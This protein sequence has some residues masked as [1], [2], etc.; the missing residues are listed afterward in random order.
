MT[1][2][3]CKSRAKLF[4]RSLIKNMLCA[5]FYYSGLYSLIKSLLPS[6]RKNEVVVLTFHHISDRKLNYF[7]YLDRDF[8][9]R[10]GRYEIGVPKRMFEKQLKD[11]SLNYNVISLG[12]LT[13]RI[14]EKD[15]MPPRS[16]VVTFDDGYHDFYTLAYPVLKKYR[17]PATVFII[18]GLV[19]LNRV[20]WID[21]IAELILATGGR[22]IIIT[23]ELYP[24]DL[25]AE[26]LNTDLRSLER[27]REFVSVLIKGLKE[28]ANKKRG[29]LVEDIIKH[30][31]VGRI[32]HRTSSRLMG[33]EE[34]AEISRDGVAI[35]SH[36]LTH[37]VLTSLDDS[38]LLDEVYRSKKIL[39]Q[40]VNLNIDLFCYPFGT[41]GSFDERTKAFLKEVGYRCALTSEDG[42]NDTGGDPFCLKRLGTMMFLGFMG[43]YSRSVLVLELDGFFDLCC[44][45]LKQLLKRIIA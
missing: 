20:M 17:V 7:L 21:E 23:P 10:S 25:R 12:K 40:K 34:I 27:R 42:V 33:W 11:I 44:A 28:L 1:V 3:F 2:E 5:F 6:F 8:R 29:E 19:N 4:F 39:E 37:P 15:T 45:Y 16:V 31:Q 32:S 43:R 13:E 41:R 36:S 9:T 22:Q 14:E 35:G 18:P 30:N 26:I 38:E 24:S